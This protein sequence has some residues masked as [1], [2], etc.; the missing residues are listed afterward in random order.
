[1]RL[2]E[3]RFVRI[4][5]VALCVVML[6]AVGIKRASYEQRI[7]KVI[8]WVWV[9]PN[10]IPE[11]VAPVI[12]SW[13]K[14]APDYRIHKIDETNCDV[15]A[16]AFVRQA[17]A[18]KAYNFVSDYCRMLHLEKEGGLYLDV[19]HMLKASPNEVLRRADRVF[20]MESAG[21]LSGSF[22]A[23]RPHDPVVKAMVNYYN[24]SNFVWWPLPRSLTHH[25]NQ[26]FPGVPV[27]SF[28]EQDGTRIL[29]TNIAMTDFG[30]GENIA[31]HFYDNL[32]AGDEYRGGF[33]WI[34]KNAFLNEHGIP[35][36]RK[37][38]QQNNE[39]KRTL[40]LDTPTTGY[41]Y[42]FKTRAKIIAYQPKKSI[43]LRW[44]HNNEVVDYQFKDNCY[45]R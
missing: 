39:I 29:P 45:W 15:N 44:K 19:D 4:L 24:T 5:L 28:L 14:Y 16:N 2:F 26:V 17:Y 20:T 31:E 42:Q 7:P 30:G 36:C 8:H 18:S 22:V 21:I 10:P 40:I 25:F 11:H 34:Y 35:L 43:R 37:F 38:Q 12:E 6:G 1:M 9:G 23:V 41:L 13:K 32:N 3:Y 33:F 27:Q